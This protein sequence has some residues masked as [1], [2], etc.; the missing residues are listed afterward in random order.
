MADASTADRIW[1]VADALSRNSADALTPLVFYERVL[2]NVYTAEPTVAPTAAAA[3]IPRLRQAVNRAAQP[4]SA[5]R[6]GEQALPTLLG[7]VRTVVADPNFSNPLV[8]ATTLTYAYFSGLREPGDPTG[9]A[10]L[11]GGTDLAAGS[12]GLYA[13]AQAVLDITASMARDPRQ[14]SFRTAHGLIFAGQTAP[15]DATSAAL[16]RGNPKLQRLSGLL[17]ASGRVSTTVPTLLKLANTSFGNIEAQQIIAQQMLDTIESRQKEILKFLQDVQEREKLSKEAAGK[18]EKAK[19][20][21]DAETASINVFAALVGL[22]D[23]KAGK[24]LRTVG[25]AALQIAKA[26]SDF[27]G[28]AAQLGAVA[29][30]GTVAGPLLILGIAAAVLSLI[31]L[32]DSEKPDVNQQ[33]LEQIGRLQQQVQQLGRHLDLRF[34]RIEKMLGTLYGEMLTQ[35]RRIDITLGHIVGVVTDMQ[36]S[37]LAVRA[38]LMQME[39]GLWSALNAGFR[40]PFW[41]QADYAL[42]Y[43]GRTHAD[44]P[45]GDYLHADSTFYNWATRNA[46]DQASVA[47][48]GHGFGDSVLADQ[49]A[50]FPLDANVGYLAALPAAWGLPPLATDALPNPHDWYLGATAYTELSE[51]YPA[52]AQANQAL[53]KEVATLSAVGARIQAFERAITAGPVFDT[54]LNRYTRRAEELDKAIEAIE[55]QFAAEHEIDPF[56]GT[57]Q[58]LAHRN[59]FTEIPFCGSSADPLHIAGA[60]ADLLVPGAVQI[61]QNYRKT[62][63]ASVCFDA[64]WTEDRDQVRGKVIIESAELVAT[65]RS[66]WTGNEG[67]GTLASQSVRLGRYTLCSDFIGREPEPC[68]PPSAESFVRDRWDTHVRPALD[69]MTSAVAGDTGL[70]ARLADGTAAYLTDLQKQQYATI[71]QS[72]AKEHVHTVAVQLTGLKGALDAY[73]RLGMP[74]TLAADEALAALLY[75]DQRL[76]DED[77]EQRLSGWFATAMEKPPASNARFALNN[78]IAA[79]RD[80]L[81]KVLGQDLPAL[82]PGGRDGS[83][84]IATAM[85]RLATLVPA[86]TTPGAAFDPAAASR[87]LPATIVGARQEVRL[88]LTNPGLARLT[89][90]AVRVTGAGFTLQSSTCA[91]VPGLGRSPLTVSFAPSTAGPATAMVT[92]RTNTPIGR[93][94]QLLRATTTG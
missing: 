56:G 55:R 47:P 49:L 18:A 71:Y 79:R 57:A 85:V 29:A 2:Q 43:R 44:L 27:A 38:Q 77:A 41:E 83:A 39:G 21:L 34:D 33:I 11:V 62:G 54:L 32:F 91:T 6:R 81:A 17:D 53:A 23:P 31:P 19:Q 8:Q 59:D 12:T 64:G 84:V 93:I 80:A 51:D 88:V 22:A 58:H 87:D 75:G 90:S 61:A 89:V 94:S 25:A 45:G 67:S 28:V 73:V 9:P 16:M 69:R 3:E 86:V 76:L 5:G 92:A 40:R 48:T 36:R 66:S 50:A 46:F 13:K 4:A 7:V 72:F 70:N 78:L 26:V 24:A 20:V 60:T 10:Q 15:V 74:A 52:G 42:S 68:D 30:L 82:R 1:W 37:L 63:T 35:F 65:V 14:P